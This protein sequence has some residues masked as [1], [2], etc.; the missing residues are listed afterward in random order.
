MATMLGYS[1]DEFLGKEL[2]EIGLFEHIAASQVAFLEL[3]EK[4]YIRY[5]D[6]PLMTARG[7][8]IDVEFVSNGYQVEDQRGSSG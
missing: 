7:E 6:L 3:R 1:H 4:G 5:D 2:W 8:T